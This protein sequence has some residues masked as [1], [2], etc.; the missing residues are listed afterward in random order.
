MQKNEKTNSEQN[1]HQNQE[2]HTTKQAKSILKNEI[3]K[4]ENLS[5]VYDFDQ[6]KNNDLYN[7]IT[8]LQ[9]SVN[10]LN[11]KFDSFKSLITQKISKLEKE[12][13]QIKVKIGFQDK[14]NKSHKKLERIN[15]DLGTNKHIDL[16]PYSPKSI[17][18]LNYER[19][20]YESKYNGDNNQFEQ[21]NEPNQNKYQTEYEKKLLE[22]LNQKKE[23]KP[24]DDL[25]SYERHKIE[26]LKK[27]RLEISQKLKK[28]AYNARP[29]EQYSKSIYEKSVNQKINDN[30]NKNDNYNSS[31]ATNYNIHRENKSKSPNIIQSSAQM[32]VFQKKIDNT[33]LKIEKKEEKT[34]NSKIS[35]KENKENLNIQ[36]KPSKTPEKV[37]VKEEKYEVGK[38]TYKINH[39]MNEEEKEEVVSKYQDLELLIENSEKRYLETQ[40]LIE[41]YCANLN[42]QES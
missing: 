38:K 23:E 11:N 29:Y 21:K 17:L 13:T 7:L 1:N 30:N 6:P 9:N 39:R 19:Q 42:P 25:S 5:S 28:D 20:N 26:L 16:Y 27:T 33:P 34:E 4:K 10:Q 8:Q 40:K 24:N 3:S 32:P 31:Y 14:D 37:N 22:K 35:D 41:K 15:S 36:N 2:F 12:V 18:N